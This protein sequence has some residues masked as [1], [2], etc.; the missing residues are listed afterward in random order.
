MHFDQLTGEY[1]MHG[2]NRNP[3]S[4]GDYSVCDALTV[5]RS[6]TRVRRALC[7]VVSRCGIR[8]VY[9]SNAIGPVARPAPNGG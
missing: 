4:I 2:D 8:H 3:G 1:M 9:G 5:Q 6:T 7:S